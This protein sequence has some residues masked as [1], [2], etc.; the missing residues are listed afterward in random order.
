MVINEEN[1]HSYLEKADGDEK[2]ERLFFSLWTLHNMHGGNIELSLEDFKKLKI[3]L[4]EKYKGRS[5]DYVEWCLLVSEYLI[6]EHEYDD[7]IQ[8]LSRALDKSQEKY[9]HE[10]SSVSAITDYALVLFHLGSFYLKN[11]VN[12]MLSLFYCSKTYEIL[13]DVSKDT[14]S[15]MENYIEWLLDLSKKIDELI[16]REETLIEQK[17]VVSVI[18]GK[19]NYIV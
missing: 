4:L 17:M 2:I 3:L 14:S 13:S 10:S 16:N 5:R 15:K 7:G 1:L 9:Y 18:N 19:N 11:K 6:K 12:H 8:L